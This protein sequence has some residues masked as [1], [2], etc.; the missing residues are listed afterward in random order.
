MIMCKELGILV[1]VFSLSGLDILGDPVEATKSVNMLA[2][3]IRKG[4]YH[5][6]V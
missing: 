3:C 5:V 1:T 6:G 2:C 4:L